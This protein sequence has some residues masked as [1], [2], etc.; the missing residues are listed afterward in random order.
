[1]VMP[2]CYGVY[3]QVGGSNWLRTHLYPILYRDSISGEPSVRVS[4]ALI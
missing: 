4:R 2:L 3:K 1:M